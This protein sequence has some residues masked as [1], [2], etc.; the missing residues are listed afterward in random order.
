VS[1]EIHGSIIAKEAG[2]KKESAEEFTNFER[3]ARGRTAKKGY[4]AGKIG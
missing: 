2:K 1:A 4:K 3:R